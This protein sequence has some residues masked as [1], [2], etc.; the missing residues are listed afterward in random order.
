MRRGGNYSSTG[1]KTSRNRAGKGA[2][3]YLVGN[4]PIRRIRNSLLVKKD[5]FSPA[6]SQELHTRC[7]PFPVTRLRWLNSFSL[8]NQKKVIL[9]F[10]YLIG[11]KKTK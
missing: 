7:G 1:T 5:A 2:G 8:R 9:L 10:I 6:D 3:L 11:Y 4:L